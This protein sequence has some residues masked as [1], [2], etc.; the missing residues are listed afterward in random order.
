MFSVE[1]NQTI[2]IAASLYQDETCLILQ[3]FLLKPLRFT[4]KQVV[5]EA[6]REVSHD[7][8]TFSLNLNEYVDQI[9]PETL[10]I[11][12]IDTMNKGFV[13]LSI[14]SLAPNR[15]S[16]NSRSDIQY[17]DIGSSGGG[18]RSVESASEC[19]SLS[20]AEGYTFESNRN[21]QKQNSNTTLELREALSPVVADSP[22]SPAKVQAGPE[23]S[24]PCPSVSDISLSPK[25]AKDHHTSLSLDSPAPNARTAHL[26]A[27]VRRLTALV[28]ELSAE[29]A[30][31]QRSGAD[32]ASQQLRNQTSMCM[33]LRDQLRQSEEARSQLERESLLRDSQFQALRNDLSA[34]A[35]TIR[36][37]QV[38]LQRS[39]QVRHGLQEELG[40]KSEQL[41]TVLLFVEEQIQ[42]GKLAVDFDDTANHES[43]GSYLT[44]LSAD[45]RLT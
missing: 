9:E 42:S 33:Q 39:G 12:F 38:E 13:E 31:L 35:N 15:Q 11:D 28:G 32:M 18:R 17:Q 1:F 8:G 14:R 41:R 43:I 34:F 20:Y 5:I 30:A 36:K 2:Q 37:L 3:N 26:E 27:E 16:L 19:A 45:D 29:R 22:E 24:A 44:S 10:K 21:Y 4:I 7:V 6:K 23:D 40:R 25:S